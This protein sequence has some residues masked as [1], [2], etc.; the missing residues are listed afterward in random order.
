MSTISQ[1]TVGET[2][3]DILSAITSSDNGKVLKVVNGAWELAPDNDTGI[4]S[5]V[6][7]GTTTE[8]AYINAAARTA[9]ML[10]ANSTRSGIMTAENYKKLSG[11][12][13]GA[14]V[15]T[16]TGAKLGSTTSAS[17]SINDRSLIIPVATTSKLGVVTL[18]DSTSSTSTD[19]A[20]TPA[21]VKS[22]YDL[23]NS[24]I[25]GVTYGG[26]SATISSKKAIIPSAST[27]VVGVVKLDSSTSS[28]STTTAAT[29]SAVKAAY[30]RASTALNT[31][32]QANTNAQSVSNRLTTVSNNLTTVS[33]VANAASSSASTANTKIDKLA[34]IKYAD[35]RIAGNVT[36]G[37]I[38]LSF[39]AVNC[40]SL[41]ECILLTPGYGNTYMVYAYDQSMS[42]SQIV[43]KV[44]K[45]DGTPYSG[46]YRYNI[47]VIADTITN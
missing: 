44:Y 26:T 32:T 34:N 35:T 27:S 42:E 33:Q 39:S 10:T 19:T 41:P 9:G 4:T 14:Q 36:N 16:I 21:S 30:D 29:S 28:T 1:I 37:E 8:V 15:N 43:L 12:E 18:T 2:T 31:A 46:A 47:L 5:I 3:Y 23:A 25:N 7:Y 40:T 45:S 11:I 22:A 13:S 17:L 38:K 24:A 6:Q 20:A